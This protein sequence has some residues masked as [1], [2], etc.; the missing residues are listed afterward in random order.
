MYN[1]I[2]NISLFRFSFAC[3]TLSLMLK[4][5]KEVRP[6]SP[7]RDIIMSNNNK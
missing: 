6:K 4:Y 3:I 1:K 7:L 2:S 5:N